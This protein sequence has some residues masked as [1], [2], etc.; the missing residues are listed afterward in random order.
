MSVNPLLGPPG[1]PLLTTAPSPPG[2]SSLGLTP[3]EAPGV[4]CM[5]PHLDEGR[6]HAGVSRNATAFEETSVSP[7]SMAAHSD[8]RS[9]SML[10]QQAV[11]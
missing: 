1:A 2:P 3:I 4:Q 10:S 7:E 9:A 11:L 6:H 5:T 8:T